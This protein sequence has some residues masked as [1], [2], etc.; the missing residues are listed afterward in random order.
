LLPRV[1]PRFAFATVSGAALVLSLVTG[2]SLAVAAGRQ[3]AGAHP[4]ST[5]T[6]QPIPLVNGYADVYVYT[7]TETVNYPNQT[8]QPTSY[9]GSETDDYVCPVTFNGVPN[10]CD[11]QAYDSD[12][13]NAESYLGYVP[14]PSGETQFVSYGAFDTYP[15]PPYV[16]NYAQFYAPF[17]LYY[18]FPLT[19]GQTFNEDDNTDQEVYT[20][21]GPKN[22]S[23]TTT[24]PQVPSG[25][26]KYLTK[27]N[28]PAGHYKEDELRQV[29]PDGSAKET[30]SQT[31]F[32]K[33][34][35][36]F[37]TPVV[38][39]GQAVIPVT[40]EG[41]NALPATPAPKLTTN[42][43]DWFPGGG[44]APSP[45]WA[46]PFTYNGVQTLPSACGALAGTQAGDVQQ[47]T[48]QLDPIGG[49]YETAAY[50]FYLLN[51]VGMVCNV[52]SSTI[53]YY[54][55]LV[56]GNVLYSVDY[57]EGYV[58]ENQYIP[59]AR[60]R[61]P[62]WPIARPQLPLRP[63]PSRQMADTIHQFHSARLGHVPHSSRLPRTAGERFA[64]LRTM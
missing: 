12:G 44:A 2:G 23:S 7:V 10:L 19:Q 4:A 56:T 3:P 9:T 36:S 21:Y 57:A 8:P 18:S 40:A 34:T 63:P 45:L 47:T 6:P 24:G 53:T 49:F 31:G 38:R 46:A 20:T 27:V 48:Y 25:A 13:F 17:N 51:G 39:G 55:N 16:V 64:A 58:L 32:N 62:G 59:D 28:D 14:G 26:Y 52:T 15:R 29:N 54:D 37:G 43:P 50:D 41:G 60:T 11:D 1:S 61:Q 33:L 35:E 42:V 30:L 5:P 22:Y